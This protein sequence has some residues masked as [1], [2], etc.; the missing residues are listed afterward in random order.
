MLKHS[1]RTRH[2]ALLLDIMSDVGVIHTCLMTQ[3]FKEQ[4]VREQFYTITRQFELPGIPCLQLGT[5]EFL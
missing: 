4:V 5:A 1:N 2:V 3:L